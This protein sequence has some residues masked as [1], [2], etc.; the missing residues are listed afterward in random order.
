MQSRETEAEF[1][2]YGQMQ[3]EGVGDFE[4]LPVPGAHLG[5]QGSF[6]ALLE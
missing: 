1:L 6:Q 4:A 2:L 5:P 3:M